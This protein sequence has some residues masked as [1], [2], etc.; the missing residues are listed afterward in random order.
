MDLHDFFRGKLPWGKLYRLL[1]ELPEGSHYR[2][3]QLLDENIAKKLLARELAQKKLAS[4]DDEKNEEKERAE[5]KARS[6]AGHSPEISLMMTLCELIQQLNATLI[7][8]NLPK[9]KKPPRVRPMPRPVSAL[10]VLRAKHEKNKVDSVVGQLLSG[11]L[12][13][14]DTGK[15]K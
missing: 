9:G 7:A 12:S 6:S 3:A 14:I 11:G 4:A 8:V 15:D 13:F 10:E 5:I 1:G 2:A